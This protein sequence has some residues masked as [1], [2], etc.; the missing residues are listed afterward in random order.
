MA[1]AAVIGFGVLA[2]AAGLGFRGVNIAW[3]VG[4][5]FAVA[6]S[7]FFPLLTL[8]IWWR[9][10]TE[11]GALAGVMVGGTIAAVVVVGKLAGLWTFD[12]LAI[13]SVPASFLSI[14]LVSVLT[15]G[16]QPLDV[17]DALESAVRSLHVPERRPVAPT[18]PV[19]GAEPAAW[20][21]GPAPTARAR[22]GGG[23]AC[24]ARPRR[25]R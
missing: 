6:A 5:A 11:Q 16:R 9:R 18:E 20:W 21:P 19:S 22:S 17:R 25:N 1:K 13:I 24:P 4:L 14:V 8:G 2:I 3:M 12:Q 7:T 23:A 15:W 10:M